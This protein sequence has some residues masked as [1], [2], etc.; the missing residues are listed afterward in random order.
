MFAYFLKY[1]L[2]LFNSISNIITY[3]WSRITH[4]YLTI[5]HIV[6]HCFSH[7]LRLACFTHWYEDAC[8][9]AMTSIN[10]LATLS[11]SV[12]LTNTSSSWDSSS[13]FSMLFTLFFRTRLPRVKTLILRLIVPLTLTATLVI[14]RPLALCAPPASSVCF[15]VVIACGLITMGKYLLVF[16]GRGWLNLFFR[17]RGQMLVRLQWLYWSSIFFQLIILVVINLELFY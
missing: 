12:C 5:S 14:W 1:Y 11:L 8:Y 13:S 3:W 7:L 10:L 9:V 15:C 16:R 2:C 4:T 6:W 17:F